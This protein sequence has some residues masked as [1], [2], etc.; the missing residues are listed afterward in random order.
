MGNLGTVSIV[1]L[2]SISFVFYLVYG[3]DSFG[4]LALYNIWEEKG[5][6]GL[7]NWLLSG[8][9]AY[10]LSLGGIISAFVGFNYGVRYAIKIFIITTA[11]TIL[12]T[13]YTVLSYIQLPHP[14]DKFVI[15][16]FMILMTLA[17]V[18]FMTDSDW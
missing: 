14:V 12:L 9:N 16:F 5:F 10:L 2:F 17:I 18:S 11:S 1:L 15:T 6:A 3:S 13:P 4:F 8:S 7:F